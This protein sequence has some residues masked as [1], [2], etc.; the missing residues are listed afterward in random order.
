VP[1][2]TWVSRVEASNVRAGTAYVT[3]DG[4][5]SDDVTPYLFKT[6]DFGQ[7]WTD[8]TGDLPRANPGLSLYTVVEDA[9]NSNLL[10][11]GHEFGVHVT[12]DGGVSWLRFGDNLPSVAVRDL[13]IHPRDA[14]LIA[15][16]HGRSIWI[17]DDLGPLRQLTE[18]VLASR[19]H[20]FESR[21]GTRWLNFNKGRVQMHFKFYGGNPPRGAPIAFFL[22]DAPVDS[23]ELRVHDRWNGRER[24]WNLSATAGINRVRWDMAFEP[25]AAEL[26]AYRST[27]ESVAKQI[28]GRLPNTDAGYVEQMYKDLVAPQNYPR[29]YREDYQHRDDPSALLHEHLAKV[30]ER[31]TTAATV[32]EYNGVREQLVAFS[33]VVGD[34]SFFGA[35]GDEPRMHQAASGRYE[36]TIVVDGAKYEGIVSVRDDPLVTQR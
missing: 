32:R 27:L 35:F 16:T 22:R 2:H 4:H 7:T 20:V 15:G 28:E 9:K 23:V 8:I 30:M 14:D 10:F 12:T 26:T 34:A 3:F 6:T 33:S 1:D 19:V 36:F 5:R 17:A 29:L 21:A 24:T 13:I 18:A 25:T 31:L 11:V